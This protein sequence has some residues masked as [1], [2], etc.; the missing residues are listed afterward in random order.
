M[1]QLEI[2]MLEQIRRAGLP[3]PEREYPTGFGKT[4]FDFAWPEI[5]LAVEV[6]GGTWVTGRH[7]RG[8]GY[9]Q[10]IKKYNAAQLAGWRVIRVTTDM[11]NCCDGITAVKV[12]FSVFCADMMEV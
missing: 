8:T 6:E 4:R 5:K 2:N 12:A 11:L 7:S 10:D 9:A 3:M 1:S